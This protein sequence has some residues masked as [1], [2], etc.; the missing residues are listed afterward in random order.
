MGLASET[1]SL[2]L[3]LGF[4]FTLDVVLVMFVLAV[5][6]VGLAAGRGGV[7]RVSLSSTRE[8]FRGPVA[9]LHF[10]A[11][12]RITVRAVCVSEVANITAR[13]IVVSLPIPGE[14]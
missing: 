1:L 12:F 2:V 14:S 5:A 9:E 11:N 10:G 6:A 4:V 3:R 7:N 13:G 8:A